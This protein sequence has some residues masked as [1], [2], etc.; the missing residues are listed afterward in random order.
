MSS[1]M[2]IQ[3]SYRGV[4]LQKVMTILCKSITVGFACYVS[5]KKNHQA[6]RLLNNYISYWVKISADKNLNVIIFLTFP[7]KQGWISHA[8]FLF[9]PNTGL[10]VSCKCQNSHGCHSLHSRKYFTMYHLLKFL[11]RIL[12]LNAGEKVIA[13]N[14]FHS[15]DHPHSP[16]EI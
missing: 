14:S 9:F 11:F 6:K 13:Q 4:L 3:L 1:R 10:D 8:N 2:R 12:S 7:R 5:K 16:T 15:R